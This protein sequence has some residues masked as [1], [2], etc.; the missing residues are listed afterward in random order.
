MIWY[1]IVGLVF[2]GIV[3]WFELREEKEKNL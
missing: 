1:M 2:T 3:I